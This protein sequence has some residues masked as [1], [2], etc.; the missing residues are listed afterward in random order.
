MNYKKIR[1]FLFKRNIAIFKEDGWNFKIFPDPYRKIKTTF[2]LEISSFFL[3]LLNKTKI[4]PNLV[5]YFGIFW[6]YLGVFCFYLNNLF[7]IFM[8][9]IIFFTK[10]IPDYIDGAL[11]FLKKKQSLKGHYLDLFA[12]N[13]NKLGFVIG[14]LI[15]IYFS[16]NNISIIYCIFFIIF[17]FFTDPRIYKI[18]FRVLYDKKTS[19]HKENIISS[20]EIIIKKYF[21]FL[22]YDGRTSYSDLVILLILIDYIYEV[23]IFLNYLPWLWL[24]LFLMSYLQAWYKFYKKIK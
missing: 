24:S 5:T 3:F 15:Y 13:I 22:N 4:H 11:A 1:L 17:I 21:K 18:R 19:S 12:G 7:S 10:L 14:S 6:V 8:G 20:K 16:T 2:N 23:N 9:L